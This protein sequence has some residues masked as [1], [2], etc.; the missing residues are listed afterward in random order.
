MRYLDC[1]IFQSIFPAT[2]P[3]PSKRLHQSFQCNK[4]AGLYFCPLSLFESSVILMTLMVIHSYLTRKKH[5]Q[6]VETQFWNICINFKLNQHFVG[7]KKGSSLNS[8]LAD[9]HT[10]AEG[11]EERESECCIYPL[12]PKC[13]FHKGIH[14]KQTCNDGFKTFT[15][16]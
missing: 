1:I 13:S 4:D 7:F 12:A 5:L 15:A 9:K 6:I 16:I 11:R 2:S 8:R 3:N 10:S 14:Q